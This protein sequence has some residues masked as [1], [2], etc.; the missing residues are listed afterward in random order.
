MADIRRVGRHLCVAVPNQ[1]P[2][3]HLPVHV[4]ISQEPAVFIPLSN[5]ELQPN[6]LPFDEAPVR[7]CRHLSVRF[8]ATSGVVEAVRAWRCATND[9]FCLDE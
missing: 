6:G 7:L 2:V 5:I 4:D 8:F 3:H 9:N 1:R